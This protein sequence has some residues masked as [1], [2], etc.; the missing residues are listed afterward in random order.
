M[1]C[2]RHKRRAEGKLVPIFEGLA[3]D[4]HSIVKGFE[5]IES[6]KCGTVR[7]HQGGTKVK[8]QP[9]YPGDRRLML[10]VCDKDHGECEMI[11]ATYKVAAIMRL[12]KHALT[13]QG[14]EFQ[15]IEKVAGSCARKR[16][17]QPVLRNKGERRMYA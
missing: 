16:V 9:W 3:D 7:K 11:I 5:N 4:I 10:V 2:N 6:V 15:Q 17:L 12:L 13:K 14:I 1:A 8:F